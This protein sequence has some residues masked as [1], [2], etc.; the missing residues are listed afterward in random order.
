MTYIFISSV[1][2]TNAR[3]SVNDVKNLYQFI[4]RTYGYRR[5]EIRVSQFGVGICPSL[6]WDWLRWFDNVERL[7]TRPEAALISGY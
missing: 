6:L 4:T 3:T 1:F 2:N 7:A 5:D